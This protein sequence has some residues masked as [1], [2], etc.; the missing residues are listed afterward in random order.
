[1]NFTE[2]NMT[3]Q[4]SG[5]STKTFYV[6]ETKA[7]QAGYKMTATWGTDHELPFEEGEDALTQIKRGQ[8]LKI[9]VDLI[10]RNGL[11]VSWT[12]L[13]WEGE[14]TDMEFT[15]EF[16]GSLTA[17]LIKTDEV[18]GQRYVLVAEGM[19]S[20]QHERYAQ[21][22]FVMTSPVGQNWVAHL[23]NPND[24]E[25][26]GDY[27]GVGVTQ[28]EADQNTGVVTL[29][30]KPRREFQSGETRTTQLYITVDGLEGPQLI[31]P[32]DRF[33]GDQTYIDIIQVSTAEYDNVNN[34]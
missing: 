20:Q 8:H 17:Q 16:N 11:K 5:K 34:N 25:F 7:P 2:E 21:F 22:K 26:V 23:T 13:P 31:D 14:D 1:M 32:E 29:T 27:S 15:S 3:M 19:D 12:V 4:A 24:F 10:K 28:E 6:Y 30:V 9:N 18:E 33:P